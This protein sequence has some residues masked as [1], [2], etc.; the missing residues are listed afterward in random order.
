MDG[1][2]Q[3]PS[4][5][6]HQPYSI[7]RVIICKVEKEKI[8]SDQKGNE[9]M[10]P[11]EDVMII[12]RLTNAET[13]YSQRAQ[14]LLAINEGKTQEDAAEAAGLRSTQVKYW[15]TRY[16]KSG[17][18]IFPENLLT[19]EIDVEEPD[20]VK[21]LVTE[22]AVSPQESTSEQAPSSQKEEEKKKKEKSGKK[23]KSAKDAKKSKKDK[24]SR[25]KKKDGKKD[26]K[27]KK[28]KKADESKKDKKLK[29]KKK[30]KKK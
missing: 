5:K 22:T 12:T 30:S 15:V 14:A 26:K 19:V 25:K 2:Q 6:A 8:M 21:E 13:P 9:M 11:K 16:L 20:E 3:E 10:M 23:D 4:Q 29:K 1:I 24:K 28:K 17:L 18:T 7:T 27:S